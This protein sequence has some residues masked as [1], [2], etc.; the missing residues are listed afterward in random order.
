MLFCL[1]CIEHVLLSEASTQEDRKSSQG[2]GGLRSPPGFWL[3][4][5]H[6]GFA[7]T[8]I[9]VTDLSVM[10]FEFSRARFTRE[11]VPADII[12]RVS[13]QHAEITCA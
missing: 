5:L 7:S 2:A 3:E 6:R 1:T 11:A 10:P 13:R 12:S 9:E 8:R 4:P